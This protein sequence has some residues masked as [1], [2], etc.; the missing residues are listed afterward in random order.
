MAEKIK[1][2]LIED[3]PNDVELMRILSSDMTEGSFAITSA[4][5][6]STGIKLMSEEK[7]DIILLDLYLP[8]SA[9]I[10]TLSGLHAVTAELPVIIMTG[11]NDEKLAVEAVRNGAQD[12]LIKGQV[13]TNLLWRSVNYAIERKKLLVQLEQMQQKERQ[14]KEI[15]SLKQI[16]N[17]YQTEITAQYLS[18]MS[19]KKYAPDVFK[20]ISAKYGELF[21]LAVDE[22]LYKVENNI[23]D[24]LR[25]LAERLGFLKTGPRDVIEIHTEVLEKK[26]S[27][28]TYLKAQAYVE[29]GRIILVE[30]M[31][32]LVIFYRNYY[33]E[34]DINTV[35]REE[36]KNINRRV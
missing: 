26:C 14:D 27:K 28:A 12:Y 6:L 31:G 25:S 30:L 35:W 11:F 4:D 32:N 2:L 33:V 15:N 19:L 5:C 1:V 8:D 16:S 13:D 21:D 9:G 7:F 17:P 29:V 10:D 24:R 20:S 22:L 36:G 34:S 3:N 23:S 18:I